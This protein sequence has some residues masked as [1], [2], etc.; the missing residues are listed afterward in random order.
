MLSS[1]DF[2]AHL[3]RVLTA[4]LKL[5]NAEEFLVLIVEWVRDE[6]R[7]LAA[8]ETHGPAARPHTTEIH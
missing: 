3:C 8:P 6:L 5:R 4:T 1:D 2:R 7:G